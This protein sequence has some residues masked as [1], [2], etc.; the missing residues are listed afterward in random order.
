MKNTK[1]HETYDSIEDYEENCYLFSQS[2]S[3]RQTVSG[4]S[5]YIRSYFT[6]GKD[7]EK[8]MEKIAVENAT[9]NVR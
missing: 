3:K 8:T 6:S 2:V 5:Y 1:L 7:F 4:R 9:K